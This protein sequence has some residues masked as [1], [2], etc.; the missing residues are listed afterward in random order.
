[1]VWES[2]LVKLLLR[3]RIPL[4]FKPKARFKELLGHTRKEVICGMVVGILWA[5]LLCLVVD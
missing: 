5:T 3:L 2:A 1:M 4:K